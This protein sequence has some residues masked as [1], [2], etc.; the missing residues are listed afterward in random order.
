MNEL[1]R[2]QFRSRL[3]LRGLAATALLMVA[4]GAA[5]E[6]GTKK[7]TEDRPS[8][9]IKTAVAPADVA[10]RMADFLADKEGKQAH[11]LDGG[12]RILR[13]EVVAVLQQ[14]PDGDK[15][16]SGDTVDQSVSAGK[17]PA[18]Q[19]TAKSGL[20]LGYD[21]SVFVTRIRWVRGSLQSGGGFWIPV[22]HEANAAERAA[23]YE[24]RAFR[25]VQRL[26]AAKT[27]AEEA[28][29]ISATA[30]STTTP[31]VLL[32]IE[33][34]DLLSEPETRDDDRMNL[35][36]GVLR[37]RLRRDAP[38]YLRNIANSLLGGVVRQIRDAKKWQAQAARVVT[39]LLDAF[40]DS[41]AEP[42]PDVNYSW[43]VFYSLVGYWLTPP[44]VRSLPRRS[45]L[46]ARFSNDAAICERQLDR[47]GKKLEAGIVKKQSPKTLEWLSKDAG[48]K[49]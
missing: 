40:H 9:D 14:P 21:A 20:P 8:A 3:P 36:E 30:A 7:A 26:R 4:A 25:E 49:K 23:Q 18:Y 10:A 41:V 46:L 15:V 39:E 44:D 37:L 22:A 1:Y 33:A 12:D 38:R 42:E 32:L 31:S 28:K 45:E 35:S 5:Q 27:V 2:K 17:G 11:D 16:R 34:Q 47:A 43:S 24:A 13:C 29:A 19:Y 48:Q 6:P